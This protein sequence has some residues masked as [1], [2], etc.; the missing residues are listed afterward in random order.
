MTIPKVTATAKQ[1][2]K[3]ASQIRSAF[4]LDPTF[5][6]ER[7]EH[8]VTISGLRLGVTPKGNPCVRTVYL[9]ENCQPAFYD[10]KYL[11]EVV[12]YGFQSRSSR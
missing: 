9:K 4:G 8:P 11:F 3:S 5:D 2:A 1:L 7:G 6:V 10:G 12:A